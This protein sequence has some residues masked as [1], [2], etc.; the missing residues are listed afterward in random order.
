[1]KNQKSTLDLIY[2]VSL[3][4]YCKIHNTNIN[5]LIKKTEID[6]ELIHKNLRKL[7]YEEDRLLDPLVDECQMVREKKEKHLKRL[8]EW[9][10]LS[11]VNS[12]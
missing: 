4:E 11:N 3:E 7:I 10:R 2:G 9:K 1:M 8:K 12:K 6:I 5:E